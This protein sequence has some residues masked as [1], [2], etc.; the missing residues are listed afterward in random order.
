[1]RDFGASLVRFCISTHFRLGEEMQRRSAVCATYI[2]RV[3]A[4]FVRAVRLLSKLQ[5]FC[6]S[7]ARIRRKIC[8]ISTPD[9]R[10][11]ECQRP[12]DLV[13]SFEAVMRVSAHEGRVHATFCA[14]AAP[15]IFGNFAILKFA[16]FWRNLCVIST[17]NARRFG[18]ERIFDSIQLQRRFLACVALAGRV[19]ALLAR[20]AGF[21]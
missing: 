12:H 6:N 14:R 5:E 19:H 13:K 7:F 18:S 21:P 15:K 1:M 11:F 8:V 17:P 9:A 20:R 3:H 2:G 10:V 16:R 4:N